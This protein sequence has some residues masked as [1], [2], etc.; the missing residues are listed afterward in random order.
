MNTKASD[1]EMLTSVSICVVNWNARDLLRECLQSIRDHAG[2]TCEV[3]VCDNGSS[4]GSVE[5]VSSEFSHVTLIRNKENVGFARANNQL[6]ALA[7][8]KYVLLLNSDA[9]L[10][11]GVLPY[12]CRFMNEH[13]GCGACSPRLVNREGREQKQF[14]RF[15]SLGRLCLRRLGGKVWPVSWWMRPVK[16]LGRRRQWPTQAVVVDSLPGACMLLRRVALEEVGGLNGDLFFYGEE[17]DLCWRLRAAGWL[18]MYVPEVTA[19]HL[20]GSSSRRNTELDGDWE[21]TRGEIVFLRRFRG[22]LYAIVAAV[23]VIVSSALEAMVELLKYPLRVVVG[24]RK[25][26]CKLKTAWWRVVKWMCLW[27]DA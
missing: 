14:E 12:L 27:S 5:M 6:I 11:A 9:F 23:I 19:V 24:D 3:L 26:M 22:R 13:P 21:I 8:G 25:A 17:A 1:G 4:D 10:Q 20:V 18:C 7:S 16:R 15:P 2:V